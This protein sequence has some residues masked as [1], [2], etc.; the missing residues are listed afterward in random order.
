MANGSLSHKFIPNVSLAKAVWFI[1]LIS[2]NI[3]MKVKVTQSCLCHPMDCS[4]PGLLCPWGFS[5]QEYWSG[6]SCPPDGTQIS[7]IAGRFFNSWATREA[8]ILIWD[9]LIDLTDLLDVILWQNNRCLLFESHLI[10]VKKIFINRYIEECLLLIQ[11][12]IHD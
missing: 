1:F 12:S 5:R 7:H 2:L 3:D 8:W 6:L 11:V 10:I 4:L 9:N